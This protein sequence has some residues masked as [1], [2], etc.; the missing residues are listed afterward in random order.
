MAKVVC[1]MAYDDQ[2]KWSEE[3]ALDC[4]D[5]S[6]AVQSQKEEADIN[7]IVQR[8]GI[9]GHLPQK[10]L[11]PSFGDFTQVMDYKSA[12]LALIEAQAAFAGLPADIRKR[13]DNDPAGFVDWALDKENLP[14]LRKLG[15]APPAPVVDTP[16]TA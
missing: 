11:P 2:L 1:R 8:F 10:L 12:H 6:L 14:E 13:F 9:T 4:K 16:P 5:E 15:L 3:S 7:T